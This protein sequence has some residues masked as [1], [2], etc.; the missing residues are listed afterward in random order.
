MQSLRFPGV[1]QSPLTDSDRRPPPYHGAFELRRGAEERRLTPCFPCNSAK[2]IWPG[3]PSSKSP[4]SPRET[5][6]LSPEPPPRSRFAARV[7]A[8]T[9]CEGED[10]SCTGGGVR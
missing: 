7:R 4:E 10:R 8:C 2:L 5:P 3:A 1:L 9:R 6:N